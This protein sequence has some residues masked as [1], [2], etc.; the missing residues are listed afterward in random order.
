MTRSI[1]RNI[2]HTTFWHPGAALWLGALATPRRE[3]TMRL[4]L[5]S[6]TILAFTMITC[7]LHAANAASCDQD[8]IQD[9][10]DSGEVIIMLSG[11]VYQ[12]LPGDEIDSALWLAT[13]DVLICATSVEYQGRLYELYDIINKDENGEKVGSQL[14]K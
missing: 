8:S 13:D 1:T 3:A 6:I 7:L 4:I 9:V 2:R 12:V 14:L 10:S 11:H 5:S